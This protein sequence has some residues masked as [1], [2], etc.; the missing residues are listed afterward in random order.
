MS[1]PTRSTPVE[2]LVDVERG[3]LDR[4]LFADPAIYDLEQERIFARCWLYLGHEAELPNPNDFVTTYMG[5]TPVLLVRDG[6]GR[7]R[8]FLNLCRHRGNRVC[9]LDRGNARQFTCSYHAWSFANDGKLAGIPMRQQYARLDPEE[10]GLVPVAQLDSYKGLIFATFD[11]EA[12]PLVEYLGDMAWY[13]DTLLDRGEDGTEVIGPHR[14]TVAANWKTAAEN[15]GGDAYHI[16]YTHSSGRQV[17]VDTT[18]D[19]VRRTG[20]GWHIHPG[21]GHILAAWTQPDE[22]SGPWFAQTIPEMQ[23]YLRERAAAIE[24][25]LGAPRSHLLSPIAGTVFPNLSLHWLTQTI[26]VWQ[27]RGPGNM[28]IWSWVILDKAAPDSVK[29]AMRHASLYRFSPTG[30]FEQDDMDNWAQVTSAARSVIARR[31]PVNYQ[32]DLGQTIWQHPELRGWLGN[33]FSDSNQLDF[34]WQLAR[35]LD[36][37]RWDDVRA[38]PGWSDVVQKVAAPYG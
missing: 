28:E 21:N 30:V 26:R 23:H 7:L 22:D 35:F 32:M 31:V 9:R 34:Y 2:R 5:E 20:K 1:T 38:R 16:A 24:R 6:A 27:P 12:P 33:L 4:R 37:E 17:G 11:P 14:W 29:Q 8:A 3:L 19:Y 10:W 36:A 25:R 13:L 15:F 18:S